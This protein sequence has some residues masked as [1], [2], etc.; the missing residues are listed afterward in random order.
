LPPKQRAALLLTEVLGWSAA[1]VADSLETSLASVNSA[2]Q[3][4]RAT[5]AARDLGDRELAPSAEQAAVVERY[6]NAFERYDVDA[7]AQ[8]LHDDAT[9]SMPPFT[10]WLRGH[11]AIKAWLT[12]RGAACRGSRLVPVEAAGSHAFAQYKPSPEGGHVPWAL[13]V[14]EFRHEHIAQMTFFLDT[15]TLFPLFG[16]PPTLPG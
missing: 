10:L 6:V 4:A 2:L 16:L 5:L 14:L 11:E 8:L 13:L 3:R 9:M 12:G 15:E 7:L 1:E